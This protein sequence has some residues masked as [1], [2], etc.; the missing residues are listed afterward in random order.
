[1]LLLSFNSCLGVIGDKVPSRVPSCPSPS[2]SLIFL[3]LRRTEQIHYFTSKVGLHP[4]SCL[5]SSWPSDL[6]LHIS[7][8]LVIK[9]VVLPVVQSEETVHFLLDEILEADLE[10]PSIEEAFLAGPLG[11]G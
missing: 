4:C 9:V 3:Y 10:S 8:G 2:R 5:K 7:Q 1:M 6:S 11:L